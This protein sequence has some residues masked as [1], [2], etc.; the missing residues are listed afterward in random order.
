MRSRYLLVFAVYH[1]GVVRF[2]CA[3]VVV[4]TMTGC[5][6]D[7]FNY[8]GGAIVARAVDHMRVSR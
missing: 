7:I 4:F 3:E 2:R 8:S 6:A 5:G 1:N